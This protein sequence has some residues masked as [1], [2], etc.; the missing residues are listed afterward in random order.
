[1]I[2]SIAATVAVTRGVAY[3]VPQCAAAAAAGRMQAAA[4]TSTRM[5]MLELWRLR[6]WSGAS[7]AVALSLRWCPPTTSSCS[8][9]NDD[10][11]RYS[12]V[13]DHDAPLPAEFTTTTSGCSLRSQRK[14]S[15]SNSS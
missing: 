10:G 2:D 14:N 4:L 13:P 12:S 9:M 3:D 8:V 6:T 15:S 5:S 1:M 7:T 11:R